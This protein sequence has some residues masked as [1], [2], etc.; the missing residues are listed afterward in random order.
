MHICL[1]SNEDNLNEILKPVFSENKKKKSNCRPL[2]ILPSMPKHLKCNHKM[3]FWLTNTLIEH[4]QK[5]NHADNLLSW[6]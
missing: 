5:D 6:K 2:K 3:I 1:Q 4:W